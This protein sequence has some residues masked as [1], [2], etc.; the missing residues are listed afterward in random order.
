MLDLGDLARSGAQ[1]TIDNIRR[2]ISTSHYIGPDSRAHISDRC[3]GL[4]RR[5]DD[6]TIRTRRE[7]KTRYP[8]AVPV[9][10]PVISLRSVCR[11][12]NLK[13]SER[14]RVACGF[15]L[16]LAR[17]LSKAGSASSTGPAF[18]SL[19]KVVIFRTQTAL[20]RVGDSSGRC[21]VPLVGRKGARQAAWRVVDRF[22]KA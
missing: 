11:W 21:G 8:P 17:D 15:P 9:R 4:Q 6:L 3:D 13:I 18:F 12:A 19:A 5:I 10:V 22:Q 14:F 1:K 7:D 20:W 2:F 16:P